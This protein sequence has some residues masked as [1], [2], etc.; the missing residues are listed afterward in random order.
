M[1]RVVNYGSSDDILHDTCARRFSVSA[2]TSIYC[3]CIEYFSLCIDSEKLSSYSKFKKRTIMKFRS[4]SMRIRI[5]HNAFR[6]LS[7]FRF[8]IRVRLSRL[9]EYNPRL[10]AIV[11]IP[12]A[13]RVHSFWL[14]SRALIPVEGARSTGERCLYIRV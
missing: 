11:P 9:A 2:R 4:N 7:L 8:I 6:S 3:M 1:G 12:I 14:I 10:P 5:E 13:P